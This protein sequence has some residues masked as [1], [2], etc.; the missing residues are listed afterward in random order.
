MMEKNI[1]EK[2]KTEG[3]KSR[4]KPLPSFLITVL[5]IGLIYSVLIG[6]VPGLLSLVFGIKWPI[7]G[8]TLTDAPFPMFLIGSILGFLFL[9]INQKYGF[10]HEIPNIPVLNRRIFSVPSENP[11]KKIF[12]GSGFLKYSLY[13]LGS[14]LPAVLFTQ[15]LASAGLL[16]ILI[17][18]YRIQSFIICLLLVLPLSLLNTVMIRI[19]LF[20]E[21]QKLFSRR[22]PRNWYGRILFSIITAGISG[23]G[24]SLA[25][26]IGIPPIM[27]VGFL[28]AFIMWTV[29]L[30]AIFFLIDFVF[31][32]WVY[33]ID[34]S[35]IANTLIPAIIFAI[36]TN[37]AFPVS[38]LY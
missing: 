11:D 36:L 38:I 18:P 14:F 35:V 2:S 1:M 29:I 8:S 27:A 30:I 33:F 32:N 37:V 16:N 25:F 4:R 10:L 7:G 9:F 24:C 21:F 15:I 19:P 20:N 28:D 22:N 17:V 26:V 34:G 3:E 13:F 31:A 6:V 23:L 5:K 12:K